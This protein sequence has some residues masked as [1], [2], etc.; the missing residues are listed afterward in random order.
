MA[1]AATRKPGEGGGG[2]AVK[3]LPTILLTPACLFNGILLLFIAS[4]P[5]P[6][7]MMGQVPEPAWTEWVFMVSLLGPVFSVLGGL[8]LFGEWVWRRWR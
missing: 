8:A 3:S 6:A 4:G 5:E 1:P 2:A 7:L